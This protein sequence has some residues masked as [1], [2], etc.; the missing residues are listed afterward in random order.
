MFSFEKIKNQ[1]NKFRVLFDGELIN[2][3]TAEKRESIR[4]SR[5]FNV[6]A[7]NRV[8][9]EKLIP[10][11]E[12]DFSHIDSFIVNSWNNWGN[13]D[14]QLM[15]YEYPNE[16]TGYFNL[17]LSQDWN[18]SFSFEEYLI[19]F[20]RL[21]GRQFFAINLS[22]GSENT[23]LE[24]DFSIEN[25]FLDDIYK[26]E[27]LVLEYH[28]YAVKILADNNREVIK[29]IFQFPDEIKASCEQ[30]L[31]YFSQFLRDLGIDVASNLKEDAG[32]V[33]FSITPI[34]DIQALDKIR[35]ALAIYLNLPSSPLIKY[36]ESF[37]AMRLQQQ[38][39][40]LHH[41]QRMKEMEIRSAQYALSLAQQNIEN[42][43]KI[44]LHQNSTI[45]NLNKAIE[46]ITSKSVMMDSVENK[47]ELEEIYDG[48]KI[49]ESKFLKEQLGIHLNPA[50]VIK[51]AVK[52]TFGKD[53]ERKSVL[54]LDEETVKVDNEK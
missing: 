7:E 36:N 13:F 30:Y 21:Q 37:A 49:G 35:E 53:D 44:I 38:I 41:S 18:E 14:V 6:I 31:L 29:S 11:L 4:E 24:L 27:K 19:E 54:G 15:I 50:K 8:V 10:L 32:K 34:D 47:E 43:G 16:V 51:T 12:K 22:L 33:L 48:L 9:G 39:E 17:S 26:A 2:G 45:E 28:E 20:S 5:Q 23:E 40:N 46:K 1:K 52:N 3:V 42:Q 25:A